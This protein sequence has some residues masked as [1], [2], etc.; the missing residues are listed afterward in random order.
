MITQP[1]AKASTRLRCD[2]RFGKLFGAPQELIKR[3]CIGQKSIKRRFALFANDIIGIKLGRQRHELERFAGFEIG[4]GAVDCT[5]S[6]LLP[7]AIA[8]KTDDR[9]IR[10]APQPRNL[11]LSQRCT[12]RSNA[13]LI[14]RLR[15]RNDIHIAFDDDHAPALARS[16]CRAV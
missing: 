8:V 10:H 7:R 4:Q 11:I 14:P 12:E 3:F 13:F 1:L 2:E 5:Q 16:R 6:R 15:Q 9:A